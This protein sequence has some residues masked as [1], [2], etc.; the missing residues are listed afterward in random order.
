[1]APQPFLKGKNV[2]LTFLLANSTGNSR[3]LVIQAASFSIKPNITEINDPIL[4]EDRD[5][6]DS[7]LNFYEVTFECMVRDTAL[8]DAFIEYQKAKDLRVA[9]SESAVGVLIQPNDGTQKAYQ[10]RKYVLGPWEFGVGGR[11][12]RFKVPVPGR[13]AYL[14]SL[15]SL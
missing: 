2:K 5:Q 4:G 6:L 11:V 14:D 7:E 15:P 10:L 9:L 8:L 3:N 12:E 13:A 1:M